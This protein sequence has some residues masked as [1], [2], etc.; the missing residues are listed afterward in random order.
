MAA[1]ITEDAVLFIRIST[2]WAHNFQFSATFLTELGIFS[3]LE[4][5][6]WTLH[7]LAL[8]DEGLEKNRF[9]R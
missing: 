4:L 6:F 1:F 3:V 7:G 5:A 9:R 8:D 2:R